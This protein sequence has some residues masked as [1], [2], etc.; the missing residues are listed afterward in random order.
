[1]S[2]C[3][4][5]RHIY[6]ADRIGFGMVAAPRGPSGSL[7]LSLRSRCLAY[8]CSTCMRLIW[9]TTL[10]SIKSIFTATPMILY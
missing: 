9:L 7:V 5:L 10:K 4:G 3:S 8:D 1:V 6:A 2:H